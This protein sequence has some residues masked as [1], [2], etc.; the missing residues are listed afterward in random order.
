MRA[1][2]LLLTV[3]TASCAGPTQVTAP[4]DAQPHFGASWFAHRAQILGL[5]EAEARAR[6]ASLPED[7]PPEGIFDAALA[8]EAALLWREQCARCHGPS[9]RLEGVAPMDP[10]PR[11]WGTVGAS[12]GFFFGGD[13]MRAGIYRSIAEGKEDV[14][15]RL[16]MP[17][18]RGMLSREQIW[19]LVRHIEGF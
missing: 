8:E 5:T 4:A 15:G 1:W 12:M 6:D 7:A 16:V 10:M 9:G 17:A 18:W 13:K 14:A 11:E 19:G 3:V 2:L